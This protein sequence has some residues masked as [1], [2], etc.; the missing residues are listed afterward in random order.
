MGNHSFSSEDIDHI[1]QLS[2]GNKRSGGFYLIVQ[3]RFRF[4]TF[5]STSYTITMLCD[6]YGCVLA[7]AKGPTAELS[8]AKLQ[9][10]VNTQYNDTIRHES[11]YNDTI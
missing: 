10:D 8:I 4:F 3:E 9:Y 5:K 1:K 6:K 7:E 2:I 11:Q